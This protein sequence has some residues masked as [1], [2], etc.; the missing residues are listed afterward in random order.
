MQESTFLPFLRCTLDTPLLSKSQLTM[1]F[2]RIKE[3]EELINVRHESLA[4]EAHFLNLANSFWS[5]SKA[6][7]EGLQV[8][9]FSYVWCL[10][11]SIK[12][13][14]KISRQEVDTALPL[15]VRNGRNRIKKITAISQ[16]FISRKAL[17]S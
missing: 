13:L 6:I 7:E 11:C 17:Q 15:Q 16:N 14:S 2:Y 5:N 9:G 10:F 12:N 1:L 3:C 8:C 4:S